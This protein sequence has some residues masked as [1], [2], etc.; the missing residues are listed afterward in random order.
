M[1]AAL[2][3]KRKKYMLQGLDEPFT[4]LGSGMVTPAQG[5][6]AAQF[7]KQAAHQQAQNR[8]LL[9]LTRLIGQVLADSRCA[10]SSSYANRNLLIPFVVNS[11]QR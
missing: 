9:H 2:L 3:V 1:V 4:N 5:W 10:S 7:F 8:A 6:Q 11:R